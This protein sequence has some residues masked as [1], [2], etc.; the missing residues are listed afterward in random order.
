MVGL[1]F[2]H[3]EIAEPQ[4][5]GTAAA[6]QPSRKR[7]LVL[8]AGVAGVETARMA[9]S[10]G[11]R[12]EIWEK[13]DRPGGQMPLALAAPDKADVSGIW[14]YRWQQ[15]ETLAV[16]VRL[17]MNASAEAIRAFRPDL[18][19]IATGAKPRPL[20]FPVDTRVPLLQAWDA[21]LD[22]ERVP[23]GA[24][25]TLIGGGMVG[26]ET[27][28]T[29]IHYRGI[30]ATVIEGLSVIA[31]EMARNNRY[32]ALDRLAKGG[33][34][35]ITDAPVESVEGGNVWVTIAGVRTAIPAGDMI[36]AAIGPLPN[37]DIVPEVER[38]GAPYV[39]AGDCNQIGD[40]MSAVRD[41]WML[42]LGL[43]TVGAP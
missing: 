1:E 17:G 15:V 10:L 35:I 38:S 13:A 21:L 18:V 43:E 34:R 37:R 9:A 36:I 32:D 16:P 39:L 30:R 42:A 3:I 20:P 22:Q 24:R 12:V 31:R 7:I 8:G 29:L 4:W 19:V 28:D 6:I 11:H 40:F 41:G 25:V 5:R 27:A 33:A 23:R 2:E 26:I 14:S